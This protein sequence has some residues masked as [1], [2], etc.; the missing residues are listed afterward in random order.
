MHARTQRPKQDADET[1]QALLPQGLRA[2]AKA[3]ESLDKKEE[4][5]DSLP[6]LDTTTTSLLINSNN[7]NNSNNCINNERLADAAQLQPA[8]LLALTDLSAVCA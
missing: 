3:D 8:R 2:R 1:R 7:N 5:L 4:T 6:S